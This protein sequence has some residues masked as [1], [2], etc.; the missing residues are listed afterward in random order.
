MSNAAKKSAPASITKAEVTS[1]AS[2]GKT[3]NLVNGI[4]R[5]SYYESILQDSVRANI[6]FGDVGLAV[7]NKSV[8]EGLPL[9]GTEDIKLQFEDNNENKIRVKMNVNKV[10]PVYEDG[11][12]NVVSL[13]LVSEEVLRNEMGESRCRTRENGLISDSVEKIFTDRLKTEKKLDIEQSANRYNFIG[14][15]RKPFYMLNLLSKQGVPQGSDGSSAGFLFFETADGYHFKSIEGLFKQDK[16]KS[17]IF[18][19]TTDSQGIPAGYDGKVLEHKSDSSINVQ[20]KMNIGAYKTKIVLFDAYNCKYEVIEQTAEEVKENVELAGKNLPKFN[21]K[22]DSQEKDYT[23]TT[24]YL[25]DSGTLP[26]GDTQKQIEASTKP[27]FEAVR[28]LNQSIRRYNQL[29]SGMMEIT[30]AGDFSLHAGDVIFVD[31]FSVQAEKDDTLNRESGGLYII[32][33]LCHFLDA[34]A[35]YTKLNLARDS[36]GRKGN[37][38]KR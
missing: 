1:N 4:L 21:S 17:Y 6:I 3:A 18:N 30:I 31:I 5:M 38:S 20:S 32:A 36:F 9:I 33:D 37:H 15:G 24:L 34:D 19:N 14:S 29:F 12:K 25:V 27:N 13:D 28:T 22:F 26:E 16:K 7:D 23:R 2:A 10:T 8:I 35:T 11:S